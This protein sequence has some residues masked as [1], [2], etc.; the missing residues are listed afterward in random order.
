[1]AH[2]RCPTCGGKR[3][4]EQDGPIVELVCLHCAHRETVAD[5]RRVAYA[6]DAALAIPGERFTPGRKPHGAAS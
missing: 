1:V 3:V 2:R 4:S 6:R 5:A